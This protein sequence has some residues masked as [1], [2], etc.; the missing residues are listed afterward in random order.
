[1]LIT[2]HEPIA[3]FQWL[4]P[5][6]SVNFYLRYFLANGVNSIPA[7]CSCLTASFLV[8]ILFFN[9]PSSVG[10]LILFFILEYVTGLAPAYMSFAETALSISG[11]HIHKYIVIERS[12]LP[13]V[14]D[15]LLATL[16]QDNDK[17]VR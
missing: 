16:I 13:R 7:S 10:N 4:Y 15:H 6:L 11:T 5:L 9:L 2:L 17:L 1:M 12:K 14:G 8:L 3:I